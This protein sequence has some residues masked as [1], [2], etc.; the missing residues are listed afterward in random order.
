MSHITLIRPPVICTRY[1][2]SA[3]ITPPL[4]LAYIAA[5]LL[6]SRHEV[7]AIDAVGEAPLDHGTAPTAH[8]D[9]VVHGLSI[10]EIVDRIAPTTDAIG[11]SVMY[12]QQWPQARAIVEAIA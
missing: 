8:P 10:L 4:G 12:S 11:L 2:Y 9:L 1:A 6:E 5:A 7:S 3:G